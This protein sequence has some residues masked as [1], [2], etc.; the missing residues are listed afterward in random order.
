[1]DK[2]KE[3]IISIKEF[4]FPFVVLHNFLNGRFKTFVRVFQE[5]KDLKGL[6]VVQERWYKSISSGVQYVILK[7][8]IG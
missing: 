2:S 8:K 7:S 4:F 6:R 5:N 3:F 1:L